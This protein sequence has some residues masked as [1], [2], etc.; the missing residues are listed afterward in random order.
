M[1]A[2]GINFVDSNDLPST[3]KTAPRGW[4]HPLHK[5]S[6]Y[7]GQFPPSLAHF[8]IRQYTQPGEMV[9]DPFSGGGTTVLEALLLGRPAAA[10]DAFGYAHTLSHAKA[11]PMELP[12]FDRYLKA[13]LKEAERQPGKLAL[14]DNPDLRIF[15]SDRTL[16]QIL[17]LRAILREDDSDE[18]IFLKGVVSGILHGPSAMFLSLSMKDTVSSTPGYVERY[19]KEHGL[20][21]PER[22]LYECAMNKARRCL[23]AG[24]P[25][26]KGSIFRGDARAVPLPDKSVNFILT[27]PPYMSVLD[28]AWNN[29]L[30]VWWL[31]D[32]RRTEQK[33]L[34]RSGVEETYRKFMREICVE[35]FRLLKPNSAFVIVVGDVKKTRSNGTTS[36]I[37]SALLIGEEAEKAGFEIEA[38]LNDT[39]KLH[40]RPMLVFNSLKWEYDATEHIERS[41]VLIDRIL[42][43]RKGHRLKTHDFKIDWQNRSLHGEQLLLMEPPQDEY[44]ISKP[45]VQRPR[46]AAKA[47]SKAQ[48]KSVVQLASKG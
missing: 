48:R 17:R 6:Q 9:F 26:R 29:W 25:E 35:M 36:I 37:N 19:V 40:N 44:D 38:I 28:Y 13:K 14:L 20:V 32:D 31:G 21:K 24:I 1:I 34:M 27:S 23:S 45:P 39:Y 2:P 43:L 18:A 30:R 11:R 42:I 3:W 8:F 22:D 46:R 47:K 41:S 33:K 15:Y 10:I 5:L 16:D 4:G 12:A 7:I